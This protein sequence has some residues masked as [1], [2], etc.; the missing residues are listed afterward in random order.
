ML[1]VTQRYIAFNRVTCAI[2]LTIL[3]S[4]DISYSINMRYS[5]I[6]LTI[7]ALAA[8]IV[9]VAAQY[10]D[11]FDLITRDIDFEPSLLERDMYD[12]YSLFERDIGDDYDLW[13]REIEDIVLL[14]ARS[15]SGG[16]GKI[17]DSHKCSMPGSC[18]QGVP[19]HVDSHVKLPSPPR[20]PTRW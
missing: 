4:T 20:I 5:T 13:E 18:G 12:D 17:D 1:L 10:A 11:D 8:S 16:G 6:I 15:R 3:S 9:P 14:D 7:A 19:P 2:S